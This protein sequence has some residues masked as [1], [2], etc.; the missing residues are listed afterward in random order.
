M[1]KALLNI[2]PVVLALLAGLF[3]WSLTALGAG[4]VF[5]TKRH[6]Q[7]FLDFMLGFASGVM[8]SAS[9]WS[10]LIP[11]IE[12]SKDKGGI[13]WVPA[14]VGFI[15]GALFLGVLDRFLPHL[16]LG[17]P[18]AKKEGIK[19]SLHRTVLLLLAITMHNIPE[20]LAVGVAFGALSAKPTLDTLGAGIALALGIGIQNLPEGSAVSLP[21]YRVGLS[22]LKSFW[23]GQ[24]SA[25]VEPVSAVVGAGV[26]VLVTPIL[27]YALAF[28]A[29][30]MVF[31]VVEELIPESQE[32]GNTDLATAGTILGFAIMMILDVAFG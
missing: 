21:L 20:G 1:A 6:S 17:F 18:E 14:T 13:P 11:A 12:I 23:Y 25:L 29:G 10:L 28:A 7:K 9:C 5:L 16:H 26:I 3:T 19:T 22:K 27:P 8:L 30:A 24:L 15:S 31:V 2:H 4:A 32:K